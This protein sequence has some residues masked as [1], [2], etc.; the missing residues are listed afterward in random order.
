LLAARKEHTE[1]HFHISHLQRERREIKRA[2][3]YLEEDE[4]EV[5]ERYG[6]EQQ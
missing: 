6:S 1:R 3:R 4:E 2:F 5:E